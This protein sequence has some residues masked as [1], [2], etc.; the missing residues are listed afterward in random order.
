MTAAEYVR[1]RLQEMREREKLIVCK[2]WVVRESEMSAGNLYFVTCGCDVP[3]AEV[4][5]EDDAA[6]I[7][8]ARA[9][10]PAL[11]EALETL[12]QDHEKNGCGNYCSDCG[13]PWP[14]SVV[15]ETARALGW[16]P[17]A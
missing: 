8:A 6:F 12:T 14:C 1:Q 3:A 5:K 17:P 9:D 11:V 2:P 13:A 15:V 4:W 10:L 7:A 16:E